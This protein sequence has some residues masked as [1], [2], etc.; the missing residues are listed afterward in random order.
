MAITSGRGGVRIWRSLRRLALFGIFPVW[1]LAGCS[2]EEPHWTRLRPIDFPFYVSSVDYLRGNRIGTGEVY[3]FG[4]WCATFGDAIP[5]ANGAADGR[6]LKF[7]VTGLVCRNKGGENRSC[8][9]DFRNCIG[10]R[11]KRGIYSCRLTVEGVGPGHESDYVSLVKCPDDV[12]G[13]KYTLTLTDSGR[14]VRLN[15]SIEIGL[16]G[17]LEALLRAH[18][19]VEGIVLKSEGGHVYEGRGVANVIRGHKLD[20]YVFEACNSACTMLFISGAIRTMGDQGQLGF[21]Q[22]WLEARYPTPFIDRNTEQNKDR[23][24]YRDRDI[25]EAFLQR[26]FDA[27]HSDIWF[28]THEELL[29]ARVIHRVRGG[30]PAG[31]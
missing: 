19:G 23:E 27:P 13:K 30:A 6:Y 7:S 28:P 22:Y 5:V 15:G 20:T 1:A 16:S 26:I 8:S 14:L 11:C 24:F 3:C 21:H 10:Q 18:P 29:Q 4:E 12:V 2:V 9:L 17:D 25:D 31:G